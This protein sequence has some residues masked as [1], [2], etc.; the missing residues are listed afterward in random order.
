QGD[1]IRVSIVS[2]V[3]TRAHAIDHRRRR[4]TL[5]R[6]RYAARG[7]P[8]GVVLQRDREASRRQNRLSRYLRARAA[9]ADAARIAA[10]RPAEKYRDRKSVVL[11][12]GE[13]RGGGLILK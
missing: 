4:R 10:A 7:Q 8:G 3:Q 6:Q 13:G 12:T 9:D 11:G 2:R 1:G 5:Y